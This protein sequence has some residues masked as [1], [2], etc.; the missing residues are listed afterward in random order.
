MNRRILI[1]ALALLLAFAAVGMS[2]C[3]SL[4]AVLPC[5][6]C[7][8]AGDSGMTTRCK[9]CLGQLSGGEKMGKVGQE[10]ASCSSRLDDAETS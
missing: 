9:F 1:V 2:S 6:D 4:F 8:A 5:D 7:S 10:R 3:P